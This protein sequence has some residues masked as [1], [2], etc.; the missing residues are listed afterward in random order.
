MDVSKGLAL[1]EEAYQKDPKN[2]TVLHRYGMARSS[3]GE[4]DEARQLLDRALRY[5]PDN[6]RILKDRSEL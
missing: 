5:D 4:T 3:N 1:L 2:P 6:P